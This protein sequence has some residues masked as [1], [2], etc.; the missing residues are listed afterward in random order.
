MV[1]AREGRGQGRGGGLVMYGATFRERAV[2]TDCTGVFW[3]AVRR[4]TSDG[5]IDSGLN[6]LTRP[7]T[8]TCNY[9]QPAL[10]DGIRQQ[11]ERVGRGRAA[12]PSGQI[13]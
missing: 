11:R 9:K 8:R 13:R 3:R 10:T 7:I 6:S 5:T 2:S 12:R 4:G 1:G